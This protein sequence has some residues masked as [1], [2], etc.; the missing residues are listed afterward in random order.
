MSVLQE[1]LS[2]GAICKS[3]KSPKSELKILKES[4]KRHGLSELFTIECSECKFR[5]KSY[6]SKKLPGGKNFEINRRSVLA[7]NS[8]KGGHKILSGFCAMMNLPAPLST[9]S[10][11]KHLKEISNVSFTEAENVMKKAA[12][13]IRETIL[14]KNPDANKND[15]DGALSVAVS[16]DGTWHKRGFSSK[17]GVVAAI[18]VDTGEV[19][20][21][22]VLSTHC[23]ECRKHQNDDKASEKFLSWQENHSRSCQINFHG[24]SGA[25]EGEGALEI[26]KRSIEKRG[27]KYTT[28][29]GDGD[30]DTFKTV[31]EEIS[32]IYGERYKVTKEE[33]IGHI[34]K[35]MGNALRRYV[36]NETNK[37]VRRKNSLGKRQING[38]KNHKISKI[39]WQCH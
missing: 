24:S 27:L 22:G 16:I 39:L 18:L 21:F 9:R 1:I 37:D 20:D 25:M 15:K 36:K 30:S 34:Q 29:V 32:K 2:T 13:R 19:V 8:T 3:C 17:Y 14:K 31:S 33:C 11:S 5:V 38:R 35:R 10:Y 6:T 28:F 26:F 7:C 4:K 23:P 12:Y